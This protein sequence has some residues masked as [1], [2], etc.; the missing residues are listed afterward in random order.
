M[1]G[2]KSVE[3]NREGLISSYGAEFSLLTL[4]NQSVE[5]TEIQT[6]RR[7]HSRQRNQLAGGITGSRR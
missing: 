6:W 5:S 3:L 4:L 2:I 1:R 7:H